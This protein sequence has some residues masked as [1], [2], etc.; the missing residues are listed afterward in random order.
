[1]KSIN[2]RI[3]ENTKEKIDIIKKENGLKS[4]DETIN[5]LIPKMV[6]EDFSFKKESPAFVLIGKTGNR[7]EEIIKVS[8]DDLKKSENGTSWKAQGED[9]S[10]IATTLFVDSQGAF[11]RFIRNNNTF[12]EYYHF[13]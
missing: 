9:T 5:H 11:I 1:M 7:A 10:E 3:K 6:N 8:Y 13:L 12:C 4:I 2:I